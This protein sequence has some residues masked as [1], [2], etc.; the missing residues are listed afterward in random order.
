MTTIYIITHNRSVVEVSYG[1]NLGTSNWSSTN[2]REFQSYVV[3]LNSITFAS[4]LTTRNS[5]DMSE[6]ILKC[7]DVPYSRPRS[8]SRV[9]IHRAQIINL[10]VSIEKS[11]YN[12][13]ILYIKIDFYKSLNSRLS[14]Y[15]LGDNDNA[16]SPFIKSLKICI[17]V[18]YFC[19]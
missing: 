11:N 13:K 8:S 18:T 9:K 15:S 17:V 5:R 3:E 12:D 14:R 4:T 6:V 1:W 16:I 2:L 7:V 19:L 10:S